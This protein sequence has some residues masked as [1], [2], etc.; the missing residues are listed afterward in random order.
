VSPEFSVS[1]LFRFVRA[2]EFGAV[3]KPPSSIDYTT[4]LKKTKISS[5]ISSGT[6]STTREIKG[7]IVTQGE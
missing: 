2:P 7:H 3:R 1:I 5:C 4:T 6:R